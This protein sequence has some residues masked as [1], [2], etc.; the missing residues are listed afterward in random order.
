VASIQSPQTDRKAEGAASRQARSPQGRINRD[1]AEEYTQSLSQIAAG[2]WRQIALA[3]RLGVPQALGLTVEEWVHDRLGGYVKM[4]AAERIPAA[5]ELK[6]DGQSNRE[7][8]AVLGVDESTV[9]EDLRAGNPAHSEKKASATNGRDDEAAGNPAP[10]DAVAALAAEETIRRQ[11]ERSAKQEARREKRLEKLAEISKGN[12]DLPM[13]VRYPIIYADPPWRYEH[14]PF[15]ENRRVENHYPTLPIEEI[16]AL[17]VLD[18]ATADALVFIWVP[19]PILEQCFQVIRAWD[20]DYRT[21]VVWVKDKIGMGNYVRQRHEHLLIARR[22]E[23]PLP[24][25]KDRPAS[26]IEA[27]RG[28]HS[29]KPAK[30]YELIERMYPNLPKIELFARGTRAGWTGWGNQAGSTEWDEMWRK[31]FAPTTE[32]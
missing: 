11:V 8:A 10:L 13:S 5:I 22:G 3:K 1:V 12:T 16:C 32:T 6:A 15:S 27:P 14:P 20:F 31:P 17:P 9:R 19:P 4:A 29:Q 2:T 28:A 25:T 7:I 30:V 21:G 26:V 23:I 18:L 24:A